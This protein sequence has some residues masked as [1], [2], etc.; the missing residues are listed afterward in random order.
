VKVVHMMHQVN[1]II[2]EHD[3][4][5]TSITNLCTLH[6][7]LSTALGIFKLQ[8]HQLMLTY[9]SSSYAAIWHPCSGFDL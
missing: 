5:S 4:Q 1:M 6:D 8:K 2:S 7:L 3:A 9:T